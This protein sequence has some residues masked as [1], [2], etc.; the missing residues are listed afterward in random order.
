[1]LHES[2]TVRIVAERRAQPLDGGVEPVLEVDER[3]VG[4]EPAPQL[5]A[6]QDFIGLLQEH[7]Q[8]FEGLI[9]QAQADTILAKL[10]RPH[11][12]LEAAKTKSVPERG[13]RHVNQHY[14]ERSSRVDQLRI[15]LEPGA[16]R[17]RSD[18]QFDGDNQR[19]FSRIPR[20]QHVTSGYLRVIEQVFSAA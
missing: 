7:Q 16:R 6:R 8:Y 11:V 19:R 18:F 17:S 1:R 12:E 2:R 10:A 3:P 13:S 4:P 9:L 20:Y 14:S 5:L 15:G